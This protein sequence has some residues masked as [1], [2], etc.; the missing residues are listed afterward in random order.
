METTKQNQS[1][2]EKVKTFEDACA[3]EA[4]SEDVSNLLS[5][6]GQDKDLLA[7]QAWAKMN[8]IRKVL[9]EGWEP[10]WMNSNQWKFY[11]WFKMN[12]GSGLSYGDYGY[13]FSTSHVGSRLC[14]K[15][16]EL[17]E[18]AGTQFLDIYKLFMTL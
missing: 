14:F 9:N 2:T 4:P 10:D 17:A 3:I 15:T 5:Y 8:H 6:K 11:P 12:T 16:S 13:V 7:A 1:I 18:Y